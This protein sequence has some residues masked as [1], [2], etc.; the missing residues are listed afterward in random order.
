MTSELINNY[1]TVGYKFII[2]R[3]K[4]VEF[5]CEIIYEL[6]IRFEKT[7]SIVKSFGQCSLNHLCDNTNEFV[8]YSDSLIEI[9]M[10]RALIKQYEALNLD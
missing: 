5:I 3:D 6:N 1:I 8:R 2:S 7:K 10:Y 9:S 4:L